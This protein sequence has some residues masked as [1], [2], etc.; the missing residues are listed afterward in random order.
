MLPRGRNSLSREPSDSRTWN[1]IRNLKSDPFP[2]KPKVKTN[3]GQGFGGGRCWGSE[4]QAKE[5]DF[6]C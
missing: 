3:S 5:L 1:M 6:H 2:L 4:C